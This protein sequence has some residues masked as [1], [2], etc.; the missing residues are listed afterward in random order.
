MEIILPMAGLS[1]RFPGMRPKYTLVTHDGHMMWEK[2]ILPLIKRHHVTIA[3]LEEHEQAYPIIEYANDLFGDKVR[4]VTLKTRTKGP[5]DTVFQLLQQANIAPDTE[6]FI[7]DCDSFFEHDHQKGNYVCV[8]S[9]KEHDV[10]KRVGAKSF[11]TTNDQDTILRIV[12]KEIVSDTFCVGGYKFESA[13]EF[14][15]V[16]QQLEEQ[17]EV[18]V[19]HVIDH[20]LQDKKIFSAVKVRDYADVGTAEDWHEYNDKACIFCDLDGTLFR[21]QHR[22]DFGKPPELLAKNAEI[23]RREMA[24]GSRVIFT[25]ARPERVRRHIEQQL[26]G[27]GFGGCELICGLPN[28]KRILINDYNEANP[29]PRA[30]AINLIRN[31]DDLGNFL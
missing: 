15:E 13:G 23:I 30:I 18:F 24:R 16:Y 10:L 28:T 2:S 8:T 4:T 27:F 11:V 29:Y 9:M 19:S 7:K 6:I 26:A 1:T 31:Q 5:A 17:G 22:K 14:M 3:L 21:A 12:E 25:T 20:M